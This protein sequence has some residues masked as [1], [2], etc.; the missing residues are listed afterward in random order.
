MNDLSHFNLLRCLGNSFLAI[1]RHIRPIY[2]P[3]HEYLSTLDPRADHPLNGVYRTSCLSYSGLMIITNSLPVV[4]AC[5][6]AA[7]V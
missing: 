7:G 4:L 1:I 3:F 6:E 2:F 5:P